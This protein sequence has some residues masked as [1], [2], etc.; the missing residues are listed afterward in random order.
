[1]N[2]PIKVAIAGLGSR[3][4]L[5][6]AI[7]Q[8]RYPDLMKITA[9]ADTLPER[10]K[11]AADVFSI[12]QNMCFSSGKEICQTKGLAD[13]MFICTPDREHAD[14]AIS[15]L[16]NGYHVLLEKPMAPTLDECRRILKAADESDK[17]TIVCHVLRYTPFY[18]ELKKVLESGQIGEIVSIQA[19]ENVGYW[20]QAHSFVRGNWR[21][22]SLSSPMILQKCCHDMDLL[23]WLTNKKLKSVSSFGNLYLFK[24]E[25]A[26]KG[27]ASRCLEGCKAK[28]DCPYDAE[29]IYITNERTGI[30]HGKTGWP[31]DVLALNPTQES[32]LKAIKTGPY[33][34]CV[35]HCDNDVPDHMIVNMNLEDGISIA[36]TMT[37]F[38]QG[39]RHMHIMGTMGAITAD[40]SESKISITP[41]GKTSRL[42]DINITSEDLQGHAGG[43]HRM[44]FD[45]LTMIK[46]GS[47]TAVT[48]I[49]SSTESHLACF[50]AEFSRLNGGVLVDV[51]NFS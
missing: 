8:D 49:Q 13:V 10:V 36:F 21:N 19:M 4:R 26:P 29:K 41:F 38:G 24:A 11:E 27:T 6:Y 51:D 33:G 15:A 2:E 44:I 5:A 20:H 28:E 47:G 34:R 22:A 12:P 25:N 46:S 30:L 39:S 35:Y 14:M 45:F 50:A 32:I 3:G 42:I 16:K 37:A 1:M 18:M 43:D 40:L 48:S 9:V 17:K 23:L 7:C 31:N